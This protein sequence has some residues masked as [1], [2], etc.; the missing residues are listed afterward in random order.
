MLM[1]VIKY[2][3]VSLTGTALLVIVLYSYYPKTVTNVGFSIAESAIR[4]IGVTKLLHLNAENFKDLEEYDGVNISGL[5]ATQILVH[6]EFIPYLK[7]I[8]KYAQQDSLQIIVN[9]SYRHDKTV[10]YRKVVR[11]AKNSNHFAGYAI[12]F[13][14]KYKGEKYFANNLRKKNFRKLPKRIQHFLNKIRKN[15]RLRWGG[16]FGDPIHIDIAINKKN[17]KLYN[18]YK[19]ACYKDYDGAPKKWMFWI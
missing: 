5:L 3:I 14:I 16:D 18:D 1:K 15:K 8:D 6:K 11:Q 7:Q 12:D 17:T 9:S 10:L 19:L 2:G 4:N 13:N